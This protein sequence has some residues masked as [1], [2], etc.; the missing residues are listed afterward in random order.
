VAPPPQQQQLQSERDWDWVH[1]GSIQT[2]FLGW[3]HVTHI[4]HTRRPP[5]PRQDHPPRQTAARPMSRTESFLAFHARFLAMRIVN[6]TGNQFNS[7]TVRLFKLFTNV[8]TSRPNLFYSMPVFRVGG[9]GTSAVC[10]SFVCYLTLSLP[11]P[12][13]L[14]FHLCLSVCLSVCPLIGLFKNY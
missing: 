12:R 8:S 7:P 6:E 1:D 3:H 10:Q 2:P 5:P 9:Y 11:P 13:M 4:Y 14:C